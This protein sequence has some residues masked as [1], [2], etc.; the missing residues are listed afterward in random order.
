M[1]LIIP[2]RL[3]LPFSYEPNHGSACDAAVENA[4]KSLSL[5]P[6]NI[7]RNTVQLQADAMNSGTRVL[8]LKDL[9][10][11]VYSR[12]LYAG[13]HGVYGGL[14]SLTGIL[15]DARSKQVA[16]QNGGTCEEAA[17]HVSP[18]LR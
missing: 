2:R 10:P 6:T 17:M 12:V 14:V 7:C 4:C 16:G 18:S 13:M 8:F 15:T 1:G 11:G 3:L 9:S 5:A